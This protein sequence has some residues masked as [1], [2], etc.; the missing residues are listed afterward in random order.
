MPFL[1]EPMAAIRRFLLLQAPIPAEQT[2]VA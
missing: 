1:L 2:G